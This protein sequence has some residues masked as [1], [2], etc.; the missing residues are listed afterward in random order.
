MN[1]TYK[2]SEINILQR[3]VI[4]T[5]KINLPLFSMLEEVK[6]QFKNGARRVIVDNTE[7]DRYTTNAVNSDEELFIEQYREAD[8]EASDN[9]KFTR[10][11]EKNILQRLMGLGE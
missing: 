4:P 10:D 2:P 7:Q 1:K 8:K 9:R 11:E 5:D 6:R 3:Q